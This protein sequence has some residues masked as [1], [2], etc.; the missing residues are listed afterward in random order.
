VNSTR[1]STAP[2]PAATE[3]GERIPAIDWPLIERELDERGWAMT[4][5]L[6]RREQCQSLIDAYNEPT[7]YRSKIVM[8]RHNFGRGEYQ[9]YAYPLPTVIEDLRRTIYAHLVPTAN[10]WA[11]R[12]R[13]PLRYPS[14]LSGMLELCANAGQ[15]RPTPLVLCYEAG[16][17]NCLHQDLYGRLHFPLQLAVLLNEPDE[18]FTGGEL[19]IT[20]QRPR[21]QSRAHV[22]PL[23]VGCG[24]IFAVNERPVRGKRG[25]YRVTMR[26]GVSPLHAGKRY[27]VGIIFHDAE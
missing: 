14:S 16:D 13:Q 3:L 25:D 2:A 12:L 9:Y 18:D 7:L 8:A 17:Y 20:E 23:S 6:L 21:M 27:T 15:Q 4:G 24:V 5:P 22:V 11:E 26:H 10:R 1:A 19:V